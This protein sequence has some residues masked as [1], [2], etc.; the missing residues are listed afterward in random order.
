MLGFPANDELAADGNES[1]QR[2]DGEIMCPE[3]KTER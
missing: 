2:G 1:R 3:Q